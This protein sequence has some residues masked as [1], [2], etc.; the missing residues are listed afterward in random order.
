[1]QL[2]LLIIILISICGVHF[3]IPCLSL[4][5]D[6]LSLPLDLRTYEFESSGS[7]SSYRSMGSLQQSVGFCESIGASNTILDWIRYGVPLRWRNA[8][9]E[10][11][12]LRNSISALKHSS[13]IDSA[14][15]ELLEARV[16]RHN[17]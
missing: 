2:C 9:V 15:A 13:F 1:M 10:H 12:M 4:L 17:R 14:L 8:P 3:I 16:V 11:R 5:V 7:S 6:I